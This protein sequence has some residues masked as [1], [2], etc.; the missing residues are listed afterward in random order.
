MPA[1]GSDG[2]A[3]PLDKAKAKSRENWVKAKALTSVTSFAECHRADA[4]TIVRNSGID[5]PS[6]KGSLG[7]ISAPPP[8]GL[9]SGTIQAAMPKAKRK[10]VLSDDGARLSGSPS[11][12]G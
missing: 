5:K 4:G 8:R 6:R 9:F 1:G 2:T 3:A 7:V 11:S 12:R 10:T